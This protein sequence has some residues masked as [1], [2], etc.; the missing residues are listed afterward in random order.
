[1]LTCI[2]EEGCLEI[3]MPEYSNAGFPETSETPLY[4][5]IY[6]LACIKLYNHIATVRL[7]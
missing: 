4:I 3:I 2:A 1:M 6:A 7:Y 5:A